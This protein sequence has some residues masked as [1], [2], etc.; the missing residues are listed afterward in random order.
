M[1]FVITQM[2]V[3][4]VVVTQDISWTLINIRVQVSLI[5][6]IIENLPRLGDVIVLCTA[7]A[8]ATAVNLFSKTLTVFFQNI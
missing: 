7:T 6:M 5:T 2:A 1:I 8:A 3:T 4:A